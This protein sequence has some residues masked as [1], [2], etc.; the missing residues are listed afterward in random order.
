MQAIGIVPR[1][2]IISIVAIVSFVSSVDVTLDSSGE[3]FNCG[4]C[5]ATVCAATGCN[6]FA[7]PFMCTGGPENGGCSDDPSQWPSEPTLC[8]SCCNIQSCYGPLPPTPAP[9][10]AAPNTTVP[11]TP[12][13]GPP[14]RTPTPT[15]PAG[16]CPSNVCDRTPSCSSLQ[17][18]CYS[19]NFSGRCSTLPFNYS[20]CNASC[21]M[22][23]CAFVCNN[24]CSYWECHQG[25]SC[26]AGLPWLCT[27][28]NSSGQC[29]SS[30]F[31]W[32][33]S[34]TCAACCDFTS[35]SVP[36]TP[37][38]PTPVP[39]TPVPPTPVPPTPAP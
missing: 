12:T 6:Q 2:V 27:R 39:P 38:P 3:E 28:G 11:P 17:Y 30:Y 7:A 19:G 1:V 34:E 10:T 14:T 35:C 21:Q 8:Y 24:T 4:V 26:S 32:P 5:N 31:F 33:Y 23:S 9:P 25:Y 15:Q 22:Q 16:K 20:V 36:P 37:A 13:P 29:S 18:Y